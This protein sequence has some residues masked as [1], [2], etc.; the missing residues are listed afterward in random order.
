MANHCWNFAVFTNENK[1]GKGLLELYSR[2]ERIREDFQKK[3]RDL[4]EDY[5][6]VYGLNGYILTDEEAPQANEK[7]S[8]DKIIERLS[9][10]CD[11]L[12]EKYIDPVSISQE[13]ITNMHNGITTR[14]L[15]NLSSDICASKIYKHPA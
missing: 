1:D 8:F 12:D 3:V 10:L 7:V 2:L 9:P 11:G 14:E 13:T 15:D 6:W 5:I 4:P